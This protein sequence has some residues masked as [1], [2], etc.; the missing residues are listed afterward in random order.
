[1][2]GVESMQE[3][4]FSDL[5]ASP[6]EHF[7]LCFYGAVLNL[8]R[9]LTRSLGSF[10]E[11]FKRFP[12]LGAYSDEIAARGVAGLSVES[13]GG[14][15]YDAIGA[16]E[17]ATT[18]HL[19]LK[20]LRERAD[21]DRSAIELMICAGL[22]EEDAR[23]GDIFE[24]LQSPPGRRRP[25]YGLLNSWQETQS[26]QAEK[27]SD[28]RQLIA[29][30]LLQ[31]LN[32]EAPRGEWTLQVPA[33]LWDALRGDSRT[34]ETPWLRF[35]SPGELK[36]LREFVCSEA[37]REQLEEIPPALASSGAG[38]VI[39]RGPQRN[40]R[41]TAV[42]GIARALSLG[43]LEVSGLNRPDD[44]RWKILGSLATALNAMP[45]VVLELAPG[46]TVEL[47]PLSAHDGPLALVLG[48]HGGVSGRWI[49]RSVTVS[50]EVPDRSERLAHWAAGAS[51]RRVEEPDFAAERYRMTSGNIRRAASIAA[52]YASVKRH[53]SVE[54]ADIQQAIRSLNREILDSF[55]ERV[56]ANGDWSDLAVPPHTLEELRN[57]EARC[58]HR[59]RLR[60]SVPPV[61]G[62]QLN[63]GV[64]AL[65]TG[66][67]GTGK[68]LAA[69]LLAASLRMDL[70]RINLGTVVNKYIGE[71]EKNLNMILSR[72]EELP[73]MLLLD[74]GDALLTQRTHVQTSNDRY[75][76]LE[77]NFL[78]QRLESFEGIIVIT[79]NGGDRIDSAFTRRMDVV[80]DFRAPDSAE[81]WAIWNMY[82][83]GNH[84]VDE[85][86]ISEIASRCSMTGAQIRNAVLHASLVAL[87]NGGVVIS[88]YL[89]AAVRREY[90]KINAACPLRRPAGN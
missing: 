78:L 81:R 86:I 10:E 40:G 74:E 61:P 32:P 23:F 17:L 82:L 60:S 52:S 15:W 46:E 59:E 90:R 70:Y 13:A 41:R 49:E 18:S 67:S 63:S 2:K 77:T 37:L 11:V 35:I 26:G 45:M 12:F 48:R 20:A 66:P 62:M 19:P 39:V 71:T 56:E 88:E 7:R 24:S 53:A 30:G 36:D 76:N 54:P 89:E 83:P 3:N 73:V 14:W 68:S 29:S 58:R 84:K 79:T 47:P 87:G 21:L 28:L 65:L 25:T 55:A 57:L 5:Q 69:R 6:A 80:I 72:A 43:V 38:A 75:A 16:W 31:V 9:N 4:P 64:R 42:Q 22:A 8:I 1:M 34:L 51:V 33:P 50:I 44:E 85:E 27:Q